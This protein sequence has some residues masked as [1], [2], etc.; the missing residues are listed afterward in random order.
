MYIRIYMRVLSVTDLYNVDL[1]PWDGRTV[2]RS[3]TCIGAPWNGWGTRVCSVASV[4]LW[5]SVCSAARAL[6]SRKKKLC[7]RI[8]MMATATDHT[9]VNK[10]FY[11][12]FAFYLFSFWLGFDRLSHDHSLRNDAFFLFYLFFWFRFWFVLSVIWKCISN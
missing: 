3:C 6:A 5:V 7:V 8:W 9:V 1:A 4:W 11:S 10:Y 2:Q 12:K